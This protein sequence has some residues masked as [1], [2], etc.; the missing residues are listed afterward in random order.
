MQAAIIIPHYNDLARLQTCL[1]AL[2]PQ[3]LDGVELV[4]A[5]NAS[6]VDLGPLK[7]Q[8][9]AMRVVT[10]PIKGAA[11]ARNAGV[12]ATTAPHLIFLDA[13]CVPAPDWLATALALLGTAEVIG[14]RIDTFDETP[15]P[16][17][18]AQAFETVFAFHQRVYVEEKG[19]SVTANLI[20]TRAIFEDVGEFIV[21][22]SED[23][24]WCQRA[25][26]KGYGL[27]YADALRVAHPT[28]TDWPALAKKWRRLT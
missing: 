26:G 23:L 9:P 28:R 6:P 12:A 3:L 19:F 5:D 17:S 13:D 15:P 27:I 11:A 4:V 18:G 25:T 21:G 8:F 7:A 14:G 24:D 10:Q 2:V 20:T 1:A 22:V 16:R